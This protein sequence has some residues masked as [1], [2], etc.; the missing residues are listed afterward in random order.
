MIE[1]SSQGTKWLQGVIQKLGLSW[2]G[3][4][5]HMCALRLVETFWLMQIFVSECLNFN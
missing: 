2:S 1:K 3:G 4:G 5:V